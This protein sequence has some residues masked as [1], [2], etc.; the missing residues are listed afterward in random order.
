M[1]AGIEQH[2]FLTNVDKVSHASACPTCQEQRQE[3]R[4]QYGTIPQ[5]DLLA[6]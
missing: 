4:P 3:V 5:G 6:T 1:E 2:F